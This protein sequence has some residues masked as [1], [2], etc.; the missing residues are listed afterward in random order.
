MERAQSAMRADSARLSSA[1]SQADAARSA[2]GAAA[3]MGQYLAL[4]APFAGTITERNVS[5]GALVGPANS[6]TAPPLFRLEDDSR[7]RL[8]VA[9]PEAYVGSMGASRGAAF[10][11]RAFPSDTF[12]ARV[13]R[14]A[15]TLDPRTRTES[16][17]FDVTNDARRLQ[18]GMYA[19]V[20]V[21]IARATPTFTI[22]ATAVATSVDGPFVIAVRGDT[23]HWVR[24][25]K[26]DAIGDRVEVFGDLRADESI[27]VRATEELRSGIRVRAVVAVDSAKARGS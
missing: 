4:T 26:G 25:R 22:P 7:L 19:D 17:E 2:Q 15:N 9:V 12:H 27:A 13:A 14:R 16:F 18:S 3:Q 5:P 10:Q 1:R 24:V 8:V 20:L 23:T 6:A 11:V 21:V